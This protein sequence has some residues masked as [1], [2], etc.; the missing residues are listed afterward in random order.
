MLKQEEILYENTG[1]SRYMAVNFAYSIDNFQSWEDFEK[2]QNEEGE[3]DR[4]HYRINRVYRQMAAAP[5]LY[6]SQSDNPDSIYLKNQRQWIQKN[7]SEYLG[8]QLHIHKNAAFLVMDE[9]ESFGERHPRE[10]MLP[11]LVLLFCGRIRETVDEGVWMKRQDECIVVSEKEF[12]KE[13]NDCRDRYS[14]AWS[15]E[16]REMEDEKLLTTV[17]SYMKSWTMID[18]SDGEIV[19]YPA[20]GKM[21]GNYPAEFELKEKNR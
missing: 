18:E 20:A 4:G 12:Q 8:G 13:L 9:E 2:Q 17:I 7:F 3:A 19:I 16:Y 14:L 10:A 15:K 6:W 21:T 1:L 11:E 5:A